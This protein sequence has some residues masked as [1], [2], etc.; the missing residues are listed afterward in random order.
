MK[1]RCK[2]SKSTGLHGLY[3]CIVHISFIVHLYTATQPLIHTGS[4]QGY[5][6][7]VTGCVIFVA[8]LTLVRASEMEMVQ[9]VGLTTGCVTLALHIICGCC[10]SFALLLLNYPCFNTTDFHINISDCTCQRSFLATI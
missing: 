3:L 10:H 6:T 5:R 7:R 9:G 8:T 4:T 1:G 2:S